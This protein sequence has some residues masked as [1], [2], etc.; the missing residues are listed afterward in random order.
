VAGVELLVESSFLHTTRID[1][2]PAT[3]MKSKARKNPDQNIFIGDNDKD[4]EDDDVISLTSFPFPFSYDEDIDDEF[5]TYRFVAVLDDVVVV[6]VF[7]AV[8]LYWISF[9]FVVG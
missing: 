8:I 5:E 1:V 2:V 4:D 3:P 7:D 6:V 9:L